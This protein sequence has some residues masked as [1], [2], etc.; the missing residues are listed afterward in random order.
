MSNKLGVLIL[1]VFHQRSPH[2]II[3]GTYGL[4]GIRRPCPLLP[5]L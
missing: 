5:F 3:L 2:F 1:V 4:T